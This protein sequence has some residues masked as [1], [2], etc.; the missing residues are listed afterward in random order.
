MKLFI[1]FISILLLHSFSLAETCKNVCQSYGTCTTCVETCNRCQKA[2]LQDPEYPKAVTT[3]PVHFKYSKS[4]DITANDSC[5]SSAC[6]TKNCNAG[7]TMYENDSLPAQSG[8]CELTPNDRIPAEFNCT[9]QDGSC[10]TYCSK[11]KSYS[12]CKSYKKECS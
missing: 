3:L 4:D 7:T 12:C 6:G 5:S 1:I 10:Q 11:T 2:L 8:F 9:F